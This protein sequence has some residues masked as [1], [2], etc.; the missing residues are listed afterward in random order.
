MIAHDCGDG[1]EWFKMFWRY[2]LY[3]W[4]L[5][6][7]VR[8]NRESARNVEAWPPQIEIC[9]RSSQV[10]C[11][12]EADLGT[13]LSHH[14]P[15]QEYSDPTKKTV[16]SGEWKQGGRFARWVESRATS[17]VCGLKNTH[18]RYMVMAFS[19]TGR[20]QGGRN[21]KTLSQDFNLGHFN[22]ELF[23]RHSNADK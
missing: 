10:G 15:A 3:Q 12:G 5:Y 1:E 17:Q 16:L 2:N 14:L 18:S 11:V 8:I 20:T 13:C 4:L 7:S 23:G 22:L 6:V 21:F 9:L 19:E